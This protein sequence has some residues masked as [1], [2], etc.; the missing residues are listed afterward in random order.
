MA[1]GYVIML[2]GIAVMLLPPVLWFLN[3]KKSN[4]SRQV[5]IIAIVDAAWLV[6][7]I[8][9]LIASNFQGID[10]SGNWVSMLLGILLLFSVWKMK[11]GTGFRSLFKRHEGVSRLLFILYMTANV[12][13]TV[14]TSIT[15]LNFIVL[16]LAVVVVLWIVF[17]FV[18]PGAFPAAGLGGK[19]GSVP[20]HHCC[21]SCARNTNGYCAEFNRA[22]SDPLA[23]TNC[24]QFRF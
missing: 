18:L 3:R 21:A 2:A 1:L 19:G 5:R 8:V 7:T 14:L 13:I 11:A 12:W 10:M 20:S 15:L 17:T 4:F 23:E 16:G 9:S 24:S 22:V 6:L